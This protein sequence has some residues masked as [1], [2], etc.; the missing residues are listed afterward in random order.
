MSV[1][2]SP[3]ISA[4]S[5]DSPKLDPTRL[6]CGPLSTRRRLAPSQTNAL[7]SVFEVKTHPSREERAL[8]AAELGMELKAVNA[9]FQNK[10]RTLKKTWSAS[11]GW[12]K[13]SLPENKHVRPPDGPK[14]LPR[15]DSIVSLD[16]VASS[17]ELP[18]KAKGLPCSRLPPRVPVTP[19]R[20]AA[21]AERSKDIWELLPS[22][23][24]TRPSSPSLG[25]PLLALEPCTKRLRT[26]EW[27]CAK[28]RAG[29]KASIRRARLAAKPAASEDE[30][31]DVPMLVLDA[32]PRKN[33][34]AGD[35]TETEDDEAIT[36]NV[37]TE[38][39]P[40]FVLPAEAEEL[41]AGVPEPPVKDED[42]DMEAAIALL[43]F[44]APDPAA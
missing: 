20:R 27:A 10:R 3:T 13:G 1:P 32:T 34:S 8:L 22:S 28:A 44:M 26:L 15:S 19:R 9:W 18:Y 39:L 7:V 41:D 24:P 35:D 5:S 4:S 36:P 38:L 17:R 43:G 14:A 21:T 25:E 31:S 37:S 40:S 2:L 33:S 11:S 42:M 30:D 23:P 12:S 16:R 29:R 6:A